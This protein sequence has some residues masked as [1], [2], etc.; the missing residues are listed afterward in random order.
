MAKRGYNQ[1]C[2]LARSLDILGERWTLLIVRNLLL[3]PQRYKDL[4]EGLPGIGTNLLARRLKDLEK[5]GIVRRRR[6]PPPAGSTVYE[7]TELGKAL[8]PAVIELSRWGLWTL[9]QPRARHVFRPAWG[10]LAMRI[11]FRREA[12]RGVRET[13]QW[14]I[15]DEV[16]HVRIDDGAAD[17]RQGP[18]P[19]PDLVFTC[20]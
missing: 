11:L 14:K 5:H 9:G 2:P 15:D 3:G 12:A 7:F 6:L 1:F 10:M 16:F 20:D 4:L 13:Y 8:E 17:L 19:H 18:A